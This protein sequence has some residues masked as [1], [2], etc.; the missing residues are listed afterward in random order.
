[1]FCMLLRKHL[2]GARILE[3]NQPPL[4]R[5]LE[6]RLEALDELGDRVDAPPGAGGHG[7]QRQPH[8]AG[9]GGPHH[10]LHA[11]GWTATMSGLG[12]RF[13]PACSTAS[14]APGEAGSLLPW[15]RTSC[16]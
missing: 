8:A 3:L 14:R 13:C 7:P 1:M 11:A 4:E 2:Q 15:S 6:F 12:G 9:R 16:A 5:I 10:R